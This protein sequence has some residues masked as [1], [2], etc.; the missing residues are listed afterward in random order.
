MSY[1]KCKLNL[2]Q[3]KSEVSNQVKFSTR[4]QQ[5]FCHSG[6]WVIMAG[7][8]FKK[9]ATRL[10]EQKQRW[11]EPGWMF[12]SSSRRRGELNN[13]LLFVSC[14]YPNLIKCLWATFFSIFFSDTPIK[15]KKTAP[16]AYFKTLHYVAAKHFAQL[17]K[18]EKQ[19]KKLVS[20]AH[21]VIISGRFTIEAY[22]ML[23]QIS[24]LLPTAVS[25]HGQQGYGLINSRFLR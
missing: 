11:V 23:C 8:E 21:S 5:L 2:S 7:V 13:H 16:K 9:L 14:C 3:N 22:C 19:L 17:V 15:L 18:K 20:V 12:C 24:V 4:V 1:C 6:R 10:L 25:D